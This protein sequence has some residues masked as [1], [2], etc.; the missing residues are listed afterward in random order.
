[1]L[2]ITVA[3]VVL[4][5]LRTYQLAHTAQRIDVTLSSLLFRHL[6][7]CRWRGLKNDRQALP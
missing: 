1:M 6:W 5:G 4:D 3:E 7:R 2:G